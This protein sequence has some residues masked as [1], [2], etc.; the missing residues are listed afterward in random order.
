LGIWDRMFSGGPSPEAAWL[1][2]D[3]DEARFEG[4]VDGV[5]I[6]RLADGDAAAVY[7]FPLVPD[8]PRASSS[9]EFSEKYTEMVA[10]AG[11]RLIEY[12][13][14]SLAG[15]RALR[16]IVK[17]PQS[18]SGMTYVGSFTVPFSTCSYV[19]KVQ[20]EEHGTTGVREALL[21]ANRLRNGDMSEIAIEEVAQHADN[22]EYDSLFPDHPVARARKHLEFMASAV[23]LDQRLRSVKPFG[24]P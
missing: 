2:L 4:N 5:R 11:V 15:V 13:V 16:S 10:A 23:R 21:L 14:V 6:W 3:G 1:S 7:F 20:C 12:K 8:L 19:L 24:L 18:P 17:V 22:R 9:T